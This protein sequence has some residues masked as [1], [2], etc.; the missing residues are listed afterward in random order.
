MF[1]LLLCCEKEQL[2]AKIKAQVKSWRLPFDLRVLTSTPGSLSQLRRNT[3]IDIFFC[4]IETFISCNPE[5]HWAKAFNQRMCVLIVGKKTELGKVREYE[6][7]KNDSRIFCLPTPLDRLEFRG[8]LS[9]CAAMLRDDELRSD[10]E[11]CFSFLC[12]TRTIV[13]ERFWYDLLSGRLRMLSN[14]RLSE[15]GSEY[16]VCI[17]D[18]F[19]KFILVL[20]KIKWMPPDHGELTGENR[21][22][23]LMNMMRD[24]FLRDEWTAPIVT[25]SPHDYAIMF[26]CDSESSDVEVQQLCEHFQESY[27]NLFKRDIQY[28]CS[29]QLYLNDFAN[30]TPS[31]TKSV[32]QSEDIPQLRQKPEHIADRAKTYIERNVGHRLTR[33]SVAEAIGGYHPD[34]V[35]AVFKKTTGQSLQVYIMEQKIKKAKLLLLHEQENVIS[36]AAEVGF[37]N[38][39]YFAM[40][41]K[42]EVGVTPSKYREMVEHNS[43]NASPLNADL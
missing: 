17:R 25:L 8:R 35:A 3:H 18:S 14:D 16:G 42:K 36:V 10:G 33:K 34:Y 4:D 12:R 30:I 9:S 40:C 11:K 23:A 26:S 6:W 27:K 22:Y 19:S 28:S 2:Q 13:Q 38:P 37:S 32:L 15:I 39:S 24:I 1:T 20:V 29:P 43:N 5:I 31:I 41:F 21:H 7:V